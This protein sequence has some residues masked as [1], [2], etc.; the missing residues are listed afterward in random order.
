MKEE[1]AQLFYDKY[2]GGEPK[3]N[4]YHRTVADEVLALICQKAKT[5]LL[6]D[7]EIA[8]A[9]FQASCSRG[10]PGSDWVIDKVAEEVAQA[11]L[12]KILK[13]LE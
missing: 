5:Y 10:Y 7:E 8:S 2:S 11:Q 4:S 12:N 6:T 9:R 1:I 13:A 3:G